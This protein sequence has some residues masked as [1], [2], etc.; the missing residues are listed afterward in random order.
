MRHALILI[1]AL[2]VLASCSQPPPTN[3]I[4]IRGLPITIITHQ[5]ERSWA[6]G[7]STVYLSIASV[8]THQAWTELITHE[9]CHVLDQAYGRPSSVFPGDPDGAWGE[10]P[11]ER[12]AGTCSFR[13]MDRE[14]TLNFVTPFPGI[15]IDPRNV[16]LTRSVT[17]SEY[18]RLCR[19]RP[20]RVVCG[21]D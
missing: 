11:Q 6:S 16:P 7:G 1:V 18:D 5:G 12:W 20:N 3:G 21:A 10:R 13:W 14:D 2:V 9:V 8:K 19:A 17:V 15:G 4:M